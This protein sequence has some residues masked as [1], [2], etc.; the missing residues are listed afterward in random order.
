MY[1]SRQPMLVSVSH[2]REHVNMHSRCAKQTY[3][4]PRC[5]GTCL[6]VV[7]GRLDAFKR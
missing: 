5:G 7:S 3:A 6:S 1:F 4:L 2:A